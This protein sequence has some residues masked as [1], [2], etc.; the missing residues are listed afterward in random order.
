RRRGG[1]GRVA[2]SA[3]RYGER[4]CGAGLVE[5]K[6]S[7]L[8]CRGTVAAAA[9]RT[10]PRPGRGTSRA[11][12]LAFRTPSRLADHEGSTQRAWTSVSRGPGAAGGWLVTTAW[13]SRRRTTGSVLGTVHINACESAYVPAGADLPGRRPAYRQP[14]AGA[15]WLRVASVPWAVWSAACWLRTVRRGV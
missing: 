14:R 9:C 10:V 6:T 12:G 4:S 15:T 5:P 3:G 13:E 7:P 1:G 11:Q 8:G 2:A